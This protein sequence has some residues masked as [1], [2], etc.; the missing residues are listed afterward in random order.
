MRNP[1][2]GLNY[3]T[4]SV[5][6]DYYFK[7][8]HYDAHLSRHEMNSMVPSFYFQA[9]LFATGKA[10]QKAHRRYPVYGF[11]VEGVKPLGGVHAVSLGSELC[12]DHSA[13]A[14]IERKDNDNSDHHYGAL[15][16]GY[17]LLLGKFDLTIQPGVY[18][19]APFSQ[20]D[21]VY[22][23]IGLTYRTSRNYYIGTNLKAHSNGGD[24]LDFRIGKKFY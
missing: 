14:A 13:K 22:L 20:P 11:G 17:H 6:I 24:F 3:S 5:G 7:P 1:N 23:R 16:L 12:A 21:P 8:V 10:E 15:L 19:Y 9:A 2:K 18:L 4:A